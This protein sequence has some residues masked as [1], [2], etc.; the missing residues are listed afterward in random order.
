MKLLKHFCHKLGTQHNLW[1]CNSFATIKK[2][3]S[4][5]CFFHSKFHQPMLGEKN[6]T[7][8]GRTNLYQITF[9]G[10]GKESRIHRIP[11]NS[12]TLKVV[13]NFS[14]YFQEERNH[15]K[16][17]SREYMPLTTASPAD[18]LM[19]NKDMLQPSLPSAGTTSSASLQLSSLHNTGRKLIL[20]ALPSL[21]SLD[22]ICLTVFKVKD[23][24]KRVCMKTYHS[25]LS[26]FSFKGQVIA[27]YYRQGQLHI[28]NW[29]LSLFPIFQNIVIIQQ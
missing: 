20:R 28:T 3:K 25:C 22:N 4:K 13:T 8:R 12:P 14:E 29:P 26:F 5:C 10:V 19:S 23:K 9:G 7:D 18:S 11:Q 16:Q 15:V 2:T 6:Y 21:A 17:G 24:L 27:D 1:S